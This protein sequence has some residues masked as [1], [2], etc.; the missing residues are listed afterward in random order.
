MFNSGEFSRMTG[1][2]IKARREMSRLH[3]CYVLKICATQAKAGDIK[4]QT[5]PQPRPLGKMAVIMRKVIQGNR[6][7]KG[8]WTQAILIS[9]YRTLK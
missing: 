8:A 6:S 2:S 4:Y 9:I 5:V 3:G 7:D 1:L